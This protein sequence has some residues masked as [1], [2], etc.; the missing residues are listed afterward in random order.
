D[1]AD[2][3][4]HHRVGQ[5]RG[6]WHPEWGLYRGNADDFRIWTARGGYPGSDDHRYAG[7]PHGDRAKCDGRHRGGHV[8]W[9]IWVEEPV[10]SGYRWIRLIPANCCRLS[11]TKPP[12]AVAVAASMSTRLNPR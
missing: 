7:R 6:R 4:R 12:G 9:S 5:H 1:A 2:G 10:K 11:A 3:R 8:G